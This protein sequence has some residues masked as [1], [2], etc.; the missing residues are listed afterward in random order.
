MKTLS[1]SKIK[2]AKTLLGNEI[3]AFLIN[4]HSN[5]RA[6]VVAL[7]RQHPGETVGSWLM[8][9]FINRLKI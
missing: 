5:Y 1:F 6:V 3:S 8:E 7:A 4:E 2:I 9:G